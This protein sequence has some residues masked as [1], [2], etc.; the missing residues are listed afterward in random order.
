MVRAFLADS[1]QVGEWGCNDRNDAGLQERWQ[2]LAARQAE[3][4]LSNVS[5]ET[6]F[7]V[8]RTPPLHPAFLQL[9]C[10]RKLGNVARLRTLESSQAL[11]A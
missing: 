6:L 11:V 8:L 2:E 3:P 1:E 9:L 5:H 4:G 10:E 7:P